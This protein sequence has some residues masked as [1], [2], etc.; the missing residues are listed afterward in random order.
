[1]FKLVSTYKPTGDQ[2]K[3]IVKLIH[4]LKNGQ[5]QM[6]LLGVTGSGKTFTM[7]NVIAELKKPTLVISHNK[8][9]AAQLYQELKDFFPENSVHYFV[10]YYDYY[11]PEAYLP[12]TDTYIEKDVKINQE[13]DRLRHAATQALLTRNDVIIVASVSCIYNLGSPEDYKNLSLEIFEGQKISLIEA[14]KSLSRLQ[15][16]KDY[17]I[18]RGGFRN[19]K[20]EIEVFSADGNN[21]HK[22]IF[23]KNK[24]FKIY[25]AKVGH[26]DDVEFEKPNYQRILEAKIFP[27]KYWIAPDQKIDI[28][29]E[30]IKTELQQTV[31][32]L[33]KEGKGLESER[34]IQRTLYD[35]RLIKET[36]Y[37]HGIENYSR[38]LDFRK[39]GAPPFTLLNFFKTKG[40][41]LTIIDESHITIPQLKGMHQGDKA[42]KETLVEYG[43]RLPSALDNRPLHFEEFEKRINRSVFVSATPSKH[44]LK[45]AGKQGLVEQLIRPT[46]LLDPTIEIRETKNQVKHLIEEVKRRIAKKERILVTTLTKRMAEDMAEYLADNG[47]KT[48]Y[49]H[50]E[51]KTLD[52]LEIIKGLRTGQYDVI[53]GVNL[54]R[55]GL[56]LPEVSLIAIFDA[57]KEGFLRNTTTLIQ[58]MGRAARHI[59]GHIILYADK[60]TRSMQTAINETLRRRKTQEDHNQKNNITPQSIKKAIKD[61]DLPIK[62]KREKIYDELSTPINPKAWYDISEIIKQLEKTMTKAVK[63]LDFETALTIREQILKLKKNGK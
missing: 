5:K 26:P 9:L 60:T 8:T 52:R 38:H 16:K 47:I 29:L 19:T 57:D 43:F 62:R 14:V 4:G 2:P 61:Y 51:I 10:S 13:I 56:D 17:E 33:K 7:A 59:N 12:H 48:N 6:I 37:C 25:T 21:L 30:N 15:Y 23:N 42:R 55:E 63:E 39:P 34:L 50:S 20:D 53:V 32:K 27:A 44:E 31:Q 18:K 41:F 58:T 11:Q 28:A 49:I 54:L 45:K 36:G 46:G 35:L 3:A 40:D 1:M 22:I 24:I